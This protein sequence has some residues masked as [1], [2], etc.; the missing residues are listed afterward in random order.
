ME[1]KVKVNPLTSPCTSRFVYGLPCAAASA[2][3]TD[4]KKY[5][6]PAHAQD[7]FGINEIHICDEIDGFRDAEASATIGPWWP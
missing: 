5:S 6:R 2:W 7:V 3:D 1:I 4:P